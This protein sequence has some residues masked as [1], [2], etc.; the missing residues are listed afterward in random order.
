MAQSKITTEE[1]LALN[2]TLVAIQPRFMHAKVCVAFGPQQPEFFEMV[3]TLTDG[4]DE[5]QHVER[6]FYNAPFMPFGY[7]ETLEEATN[8][9]L[10]RINKIYE[11]PEEQQEYAWLYVHNICFLPKGVT[12]Y[13]DVPDFNTYYQKESAQ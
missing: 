7:G 1:L 3:D 13:K 6:I 11:L 8:A 4:G 2:Y 10:E 5:P 9:A 12:T